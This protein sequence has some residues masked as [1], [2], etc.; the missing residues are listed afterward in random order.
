VSIDREAEQRTRSM[1]GH[2]IRNE[3]DALESE[4]L[5]ID[6]DA[7]RSVLRLCARAA[8]YVAVNVAERWPTDAELEEIARHT[9]ASAS[10]FT[11]AKDNVFAYLSRVALGGERPEQVFD[12]EGVAAGLPL[13]ATSTLILAFRPEDKHWWEYLDVIWDAFDIAD[14]LSLDVTPA[15]VLRARWQA[16]A[17]RTP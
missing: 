8:A 17:A 3:F 9:A 7:F 5:A 10:G 2:V 14:R 13:L 1:M 4:I 11:I 12:S 16:L 6:D 15:L